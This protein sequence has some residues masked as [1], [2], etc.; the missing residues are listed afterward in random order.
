MLVFLHSILQKTPYMKK[1]D[2]HPDDINRIVLGVAPPEFLIEVLFRTLAVYLVLLIMVRMMGKRLSGQLTIS[3]M[4]V[5]LTLGAIVSPA[6][7]TPQNGILQGILTLLCALAFHRGLNFLEFKSKKLEKLDHGS[8]SL[9][10]KNGILVLDES[11]R[12]LFIPCHRDESRRY[13]PV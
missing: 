2:I 10:I 12:A 4:T 11:N 8:V 5:M 9:I 7:Q 1:E 6:M 3:E 13:P